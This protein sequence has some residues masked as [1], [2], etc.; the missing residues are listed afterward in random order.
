MSSHLSVDQVRL[1]LAP[2]FRSIEVRTLAFQLGSDVLNLATVVRLS[3]KSFGVL[4]RDL[5]EL[6]RT[7]EGFGDPRLQFHYRVM[8]IRQWDSVAKWLAK[9]RLGFGKKSVRLMR[10][11][12]LGEMRGYI[13]SMSFVERPEEWPLF[14]AQSTWTPDTAKSGESDLA[15]KLGQV[16]HDDNL[17][18]NLSA[19]G[20][21]SIIDACRVFLGSRP[22]AEPSYAADVYVAAPVMAA[23][24][25]LR[26]SPRRKTLQVEYR[27]HPKLNSQLKVY[28]EIDGSGGTTPTKLKQ[29]EGNGMD[30]MAET[31]FVLPDKH[32]QLTVRLAHTALGQ[33][34]SMSASQREL[35]PQEEQNPLWPIL[36]QF[37]PAGKFSELLLDTPT[38]KD[39]A[40]KEQQWF[41]RHIGWML[42][43][44]GFSNIVLGPFEYLKQPNSSIR[45]G[46][47]DI[48]GFNRERN[49]L[50]LASCT[51]GPPKDHDYANLVN[52]RALLVPKLD[53]E[54]SFGLS[55]A[56][57]TAAGEV[58]VPEQYR[59][60][61]SHIAVF[62]AR[63]LSRLSIELDGG[64]NE[65]FFERLQSA[66]S[67]TWL[68]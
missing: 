58:V 63:H 36:K 27:A 65:T 19:H 57:F 47:L 34:T 25:K 61:P 49:I 55:L 48:L 11:I 5:T 37:C 8:P 45:Q 1:S 31:P 3:S 12:L 18:R 46:S 52:L 26:Y 9:G 40:A 15:Q 4:G 54:V 42:A 53:K 50:L 67:A 56:I 21:R 22:D 59:A 62:D 20:Y 44:Y 24:Q 7:K 39:G 23:L 35:L 68:S 38:Q 28:A 2:T 30:W 17:R 29:L 6:L 14:Q 32:Q 66:K 41:E 33:I 51:I 13:D 43:L 60:H 16:R 10:P 64:N